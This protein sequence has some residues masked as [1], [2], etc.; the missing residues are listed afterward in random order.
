MSTLLEIT[1]LKT[2]MRKKK[3]RL[4][5]EFTSNDTTKLIQLLS[6][7]IIDIVTYINRNMKNKASW[8]CRKLLDDKER[9]KCLLLYAIKSKQTIIEALKNKSD[10]QKNPATQYVIHKEIQ[11]H[12]TKLN[13]LLDQFN[14]L[15]YAD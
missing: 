3:R 15:S 1:G 2:Y 7:P 6:K 8:T 9:S 11:V 14:S 10:L 13:E 5:N 12:Q 4:L